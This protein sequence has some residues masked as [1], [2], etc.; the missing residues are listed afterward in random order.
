MFGF[1]QLTLLGEFITSIPSNNTTS[2]SMSKSSSASKSTSSITTASTTTTSLCTDF[3]ITSTVI[4]LF[5]FDNNINDI[6]LDLYEN[7]TEVFGGELKIDYSYL[8]EEFDKGYNVT[9]LSS[10]SNTS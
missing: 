5:N 6:L 1:D 7:E 8:D 3:T 10:I 2:T 9:D 4:K